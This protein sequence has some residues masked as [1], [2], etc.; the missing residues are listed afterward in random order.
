MIGRFTLGLAGLTLALAA[1]AQEAPAPTAP[2]PT[3]Q[4]AA[5]THREGAAARTGPEI[6]AETCVYCHDGQGWGTRSLARRSAP[7]QEE[8]LKRAFLPPVLVRHVVRH[9]IGSMPQFTPTEISDE[10]LDVLAAWLDANN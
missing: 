10:E 3:V 5:P 1:S 8:L 2:A 4:S 7:G 9:G 6:F